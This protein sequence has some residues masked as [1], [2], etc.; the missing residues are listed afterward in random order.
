MSLTSKLA[1][2]D[3]FK[4]CR[5]KALDYMGGYNKFGTMFLTESFSTLPLK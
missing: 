2:C 5:S 3:E 4:K 1:F